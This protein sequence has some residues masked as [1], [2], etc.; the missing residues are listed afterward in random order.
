VDSEHSAL[1]Q[2]VAAAGC[3]SVVSLVLTASGG[4]FFGWTRAQL[5]TARK[6]EALAHPTW[7]MGEKISIDS[8][9]LINKGLEIIEAHH[10]FAVPYEKIEVIIHPQSVIHALVRMNDGAL[11]AHMGV[12][13][14]RVPIAYALHYP[15]RKT[16]NTAP[17]DLAALSR[18]EF[19]LPDEETFPA[20]RLARLAGSRGD[21]ATCALN[22][23]NEVAVHAF[24]EGRLSF[25]GIAEVVE[26]VLERFDGG[27]L[28]TYEEVQHVDTLA[29][30]VAR[31]VVKTLQE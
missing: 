22:A 3:D 11:L 8:A 10:L 29:R 4:P 31:E 19:A 2:L 24:L 28:G 23:A 6:E 14:M 30:N 15:K 13:D 5:L 16:L 12:A 25:L 9:T 7:S 26:A 17:L 27:G 21:R 1:F 18:L 20:V